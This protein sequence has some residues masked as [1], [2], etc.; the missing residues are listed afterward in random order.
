MLQSDRI[1][2]IIKAVQ[3]NIC[4]LTEVHMKKS[5]SC[6]IS[7]LINLMLFFTSLLFMAIS[8]GMTDYWERYPIYIPE[9]IMCIAFIV[10]AL[11]VPFTANF[12]L[13]RFWYKKFGISKLWVAVPLSFTYLVLVYLLSVFIFFIPDWA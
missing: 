5:A 13:Y 11:A 7:V 4:R 1:C 8:F 10:I 9:L 12:L 6:I 3:Y 2:V